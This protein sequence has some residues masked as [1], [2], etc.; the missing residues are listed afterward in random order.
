MSAYRIIFTRRFHKD[1][2]GLPRNVQDKADNQIRRL[3]EGAFTHPSLGF[4]KM[5]GEENVWE[6]RVTIN[7]R[8]VFMIDERYIVLLKIGTHDILR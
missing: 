5:A 6:A 7:Y 4:K 3:A 1:Y 2:A 8:M